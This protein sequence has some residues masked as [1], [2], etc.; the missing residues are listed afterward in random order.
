MLI[1][2]LKIFLFIFAIKCVRNFIKFQFFFSGISHSALSDMK[3]IE[4]ENV[5]TASSLSTL[6]K[7]RISDSDSFFDDYAFATGFSMNRN[8]NSAFGS[9]KGLDTLLS[10]SNSA[11]SQWVIIDDVPAEA[12]KS[13]YGKPGTS[14]IIATM[15]SC[16]CVYLIDIDLFLSSRETNKK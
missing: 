4:Q 11:K 1:I 16:F 3:T 8:A 15:M 5:Q 2:L 13:T 9:N 14:S 6:G 7:L 10:E 12:P